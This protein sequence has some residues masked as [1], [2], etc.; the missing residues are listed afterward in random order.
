M[1]NF[2]RPLRALLATWFPGGNADLILF[3]LFLFMAC[4]LVFITARWI[5]RSA[6]KFHAP[7]RQFF[8]EHPVPMWVYEWGACGSWR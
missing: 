4:V 1:G 5:F 2:Y 3:F 7:F 8:S 6:E